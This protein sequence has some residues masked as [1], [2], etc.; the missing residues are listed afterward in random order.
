[1]ETVLLTKMNDEKDQFEMKLVF[2]D[3]IKQKSKELSKNE[4]NKNRQKPTKIGR[5]IEK[6]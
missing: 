4:E 3:L 2:F 5:F 6:K 1:M